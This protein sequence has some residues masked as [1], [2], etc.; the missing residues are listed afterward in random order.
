MHATSETV[1]PASKT[2]A[3]G[4]R[5][6]PPWRLLCLIGLLV[7]SIFLFWPELAALARL[8][9]DDDRYTHILIVPPCCVTLFMLERRKI[10]T[11]S[12]CNLAAGVVLLLVGAAAV[13]LRIESPNLPAGGG[14]ALT[15]LLFV[16]WVL[17]AGAI[18]YGTGVLQHTSAL[19]LLLLMVPLPGSMVSR[20]TE[21]LQTGSAAVASSLFGAA[22]I[23]FSRSGTAFCLPKVD[24][25]VA[26]E[27]S[28]IRAGFILLILSLVLGD[29]FLGRGPLK[30]A[31]VAASIPLTI[32]K[33]GLRIFVLSVLG[34]YLNPSFL[35]GRWHRY[36][37]VPFFI[38]AFAALLVM[39]WLLRRSEAALEIR[40]HAGNSETDRLPPSPVATEVRLD[41]AEPRSGD[42][43][44]RLHRFQLHLAMAGFGRILHR[45][46]R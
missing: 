9:L 30:V 42:R 29:L 10:G 35:F 7:V 13:L 17:S 38:L 21:W 27:C 8:A 25:E 6:S 15:I 11:G 37:G 24:I 22:G 32:A 34:M 43:R 14:L 45:Q 16:G 18:C 31:L 12:T 39:I 41:A 46:S 36:G 33:N 4:R 40:R 3:V 44:R 23:P 20:L 19:L 5:Q 26:A 2:S 1:P 28:G